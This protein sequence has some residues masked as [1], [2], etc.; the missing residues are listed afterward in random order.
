[1]STLPSL[2]LS[3]SLLLLSLVSY[4]IPIMTV[5]REYRASPR[6]SVSEILNLESSQRSIVVGMMSM[7][8]FVILYELQRGNTESILC[9]V[10][11]IIGIFGVILIKEDT[12]THYVFATVVFSSIL[13]FMN[14]HRKTQPSTVLTLLFISQMVLTTYLAYRASRGD[15]RIAEH[16]MI[17]IGQFAL[18]YLLIHPSS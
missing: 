2:S 6:Q 1:M 10:M 17:L 3:T 7:T 16:E 12:K 13:C 9:I 11:L 4:S 14:I 15:D 18:F 8:F 5:Y